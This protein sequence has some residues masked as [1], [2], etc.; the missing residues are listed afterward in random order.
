MFTLAEKCTLA[1]LLKY[2]RRNECDGILPG[3]NDNVAQQSEEHSAVERKRK[4]SSVTSKQRE[5]QAVDI[6]DI[7]RHVLQSRYV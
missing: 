7:G 1:Q 6:L 5:I 3:K 2:D 4:A